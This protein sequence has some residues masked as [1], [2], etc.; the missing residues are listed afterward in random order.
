MYLAGGLKFRCPACDRISTNT[1]ECNSREEREDD[2]ICDWKVYGLFG[3]LGE[4]TY[5]YV[6]DQLKGGRMVMP[7]SW[8]LRGVTA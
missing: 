5:V 4:G 2:K 1:D 3:D 7:I 8:G 6:K